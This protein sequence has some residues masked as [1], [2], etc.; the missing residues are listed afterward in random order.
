MRILENGQLL[1]SILEA[2]KEIARTQGDMSLKQIAKGAT[3]AG[4]AVE[5]FCSPKRILSS[6][7]IFRVRP[8]ARIELLDR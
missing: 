8:I 2:N 5:A 7:G 3:S 1:I 6:K 4:V